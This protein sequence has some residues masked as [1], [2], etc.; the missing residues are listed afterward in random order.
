M[1]NINIDIADLLSV[2]VRFVVLIGLFV[3]MVVV[4]MLMSRLFLFTFLPFVLEMNLFHYLGICFVFSMLKLCTPYTDTITNIN[5]VLTQV[6]SKDVY[7][8][9]TIQKFS[10]T[11]LILIVGVIIS[12][13]I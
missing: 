6:Y 9:T 12:T 3:Y 8:T 7:W 11:T 13:L 10:I 2:I 4:F 5:N 1:K